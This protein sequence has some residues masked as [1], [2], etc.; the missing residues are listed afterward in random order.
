MYIDDPFRCIV[1]FLNSYIGFFNET[2]TPLANWDFRLDKYKQTEIKIL[3]VF[4]LIV[5]AF[6]LLY[7]VEQHQ[8]HSC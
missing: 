2:F 8:I 3:L 6:I 1:Y 4:F 5:K 7:P